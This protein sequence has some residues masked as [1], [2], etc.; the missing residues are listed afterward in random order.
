[1]GTAVD[2]SCPTNPKAQWNLSLTKEEVLG[3]LQALKKFKFS[4]TD[5]ILGIR[6]SKNAPED[7]V[8]K[9][10]ISFVE[11]KPILMA[12]NEFR[13]TIGY[14]QLR[15]TLFSILA[16]KESGKEV[17]VFS[18][19]GFGHGVGLCQW[20]ARALGRQGKSYTDI[21]EHYYPRAQLFIPKLISRNSP[22]RA[23]QT[24]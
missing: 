8:Q 18:G 2:E 14:E 5:E 9:V 10:E 13:A 23:E 16:K 11:S 4:D 1:M 12:A 24:R 17:F 3:K 15:S 22:E 20:G 19:K 21:L 6:V 7:R